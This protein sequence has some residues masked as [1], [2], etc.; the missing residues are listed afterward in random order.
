VVAAVVRVLS[1]QIPLWVYFMAPG[2]TLT[3]VILGFWL[4]GVQG[5]SQAR[6]AKTAEY[7][8]ELREHLLEIR[9]SLD[10]L[11]QF[12]HEITDEVE[13]VSEILADKVIEMLN[14]Y[15]A[16]K[17]WFPCHTRDRLEPGLI[18]EALEM[19]L[20]LIREEG[21]DPVSLEDFNTLLNKLK[22]TNLHNGFP[23][24]AISGS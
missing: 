1:S 17:P 2:A 10:V 23:R 14:Y 5:R 20:S 4:S 21:E 19:G 13:G 15:E 7:L 24:I 22:E 8:T 3:G 12:E 11:P 16:H 6:Y 9:W 18:V